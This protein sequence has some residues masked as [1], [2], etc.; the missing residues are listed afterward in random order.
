MAQIVIPDETLLRAP[1]LWRG[2]PPMGKVVASD[3]A[4]QLAANYGLQA[5]FFNDCGFQDI[6][7]HTPPQ[8][9][10]PDQRF[11]VMNGLAG[12]RLRSTNTFDLR[13]LT[14]KPGFYGRSP[15]GS[16]GYFIGARISGLLFGGN[17]LISIGAG[18]VD[19]TAFSLSASYNGSGTATAKLS[20]VFYGVAGFSTTGVYFTGNEGPATLACNARE[21]DSADFYKNG[22]LAESVSTADLNYI[23]VYDDGTRFMYIQDGNPF[24]GILSICWATAWPVPSAIARTVTENPYILLD[25]A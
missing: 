2:S 5:V 6:F 19:G 14:N 12:V 17:Q 20:S 25:V 23:P 22:R 9:F 24:R 1:E 8:T 3:F 13:C 16:N 18:G 7:T 15:V 11:R 4:K 21:Y 10:N